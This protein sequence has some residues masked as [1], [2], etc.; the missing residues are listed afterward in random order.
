MTEPTETTETTADTSSADLPLLPPLMDSINNHLTRLAVHAA[1]HGH[2]A[3]AEGRKATEGPIPECISE[4]IS[5]LTMSLCAL[6]GPEN[7][8]AQII[9]PRDLPEGLVEQLQDVART[10]AARIG[11]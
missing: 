7:Q 3:A 1:N 2:T 4:Q 10:E 6:V 9:L 11:R 8:N 5:E